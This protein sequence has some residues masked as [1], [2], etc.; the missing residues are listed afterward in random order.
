MHPACESCIASRKRRFGEQASLLQCSGIKEDVLEGMPVSAYTEEEKESLRDLLDIARWSRKQ[1][2]I[3]LRSY[4]ELMAKCTSLRKVTRIGRQAGKSETLAIFSLH[5]AFTHKD[6]KVL[7]IAPQESQIKLIFERFEKWRGV[8]KEFDSSVAN[9]VKDPYTLKLRNGS[10]VL[11]MT[12]GTKSGMAAS[13]IRGQSADV[14]VLDEADYLSTEDIN[15]IMMVLTKTDESEDYNK[16]L[17]ASSTPTG[18]HKHFYKWCGSERFKEFHFRSQESPTWGPDMESQFLDLYGSKES[19][20]WLH[21]VEADFGEQLQ[22][23]YPHVWVDRAKENA[24]LFFGEQGKW[25][26]KAQIPKAGCIYVIGV[27]WNSAKNGV[28]IVVVEYD[29]GMVNEEDFHAG[30]RGRFR[31]VSRESVGDIEYAQTKAVNRIIEL[32]YMWNP[33]HIYVDAGYGHQ[34][35]EDLRRYGHKHSESRMV[36]KLRAVDMASMCEVRDPHTKQ[37]IKKHMKPFMVNNSRMF[38]EKNLIVLNKSDKE[39]EKQFRDY[40]IDHTTTEGRPVYAK[41]NDHVLDA[42]NLA[43]LAYT[44]EFTDLGRPIYATNMRIT[45]K[46]GEKPKLT[47]SE[48]PEE[49]PDGSVKVIDK[50]AKNPSIVSPRDIPVDTRSWFGQHRLWKAGKYKSQKHNRPTKRSI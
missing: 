35:V 5:Y 44:L 4:Q 40:V 30:I 36:Q 15:T 19:A 26:Y 21:E 9:Y 34:Q 47:P 16:M 29:T 42:F 46:F 48:F 1:L 45:G 18:A 20:E 25:D 39:L 17:W 43:I 24:R 27:D 13:N 7:I 10:Q 38:F 2:G 49:N 6:K 14:V 12:A 33:R 3:T 31:V 32:N 28:Q 22:G 37:M 41:G 23:V 50:T 11:G 8:S